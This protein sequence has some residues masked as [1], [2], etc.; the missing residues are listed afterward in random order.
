M[1]RLSVV[2]V[3]AFAFPAAAC[4]SAA[5][6]GLV[7]KVVISPAT[8]VCVAGKSCTA[9]AKHVWLVFSRNG[10]VV[11]RTQTGNDGSYR[12]VLAPGPYGVVSPN[13]RI[14][15]G[16]E[17]RHVVVGSGRFRHVNFTLDVGI[18]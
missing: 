3:L 12:I 18:R 7:G 14:G 16:L 5:T 4:G 6:A 1:K 15:R 2:L 10:K 9:P 13:Q 8:P 11:A 17:P